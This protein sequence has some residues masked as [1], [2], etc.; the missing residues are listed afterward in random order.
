MSFLGNTKTKQK[1]EEIDEMDAWFKEKFLDSKRK[2][3]DQIY[4]ELKG[5]FVILTK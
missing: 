4:E 1:Q 5:V 3:K 2:L